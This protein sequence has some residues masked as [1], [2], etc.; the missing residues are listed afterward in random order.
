MAQN[1]YTGVDAQINDASQ[2]FNRQNRLATGGMLGGLLCFGIGLL[3]FGIGLIT[4]HKGLMTAGLGC[5][6]IAYGLHRDAKNGYSSG[7]DS[8]E[9]E[10]AA[11]ER[12][13]HRMERAIGA[14][15]TQT[16]KY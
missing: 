1:P 10:L 15:L 8:A 14:S 3:C 16:H 5:T 4:G 6:A 12:D 13:R 9:R 7:I 11:I 2:E